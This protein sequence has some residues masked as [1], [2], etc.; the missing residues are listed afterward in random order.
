M[1]K[2]TYG[3]VSLI[4]NSADGAPT[5]KIEA[6]PQILL[7]LKNIFPRMMKSAHGY[8]TIQSTDEVCRNIEWFLMRYDLKI[9]PKALAAL[10][11]GSK[12][13]KDTIQRLEDLIDP[14][15]VA[16][17][18]PLAIPARDY[19]RQGAEIL[20]ARGG[21]LLADDVG[22]GKTV[23]AIA[24]LAAEPQTLP[25]VIVTLAG[26]M[27]SQWADHFKRFMPGASVH[28]VK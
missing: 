28:V 12:G 8:V 2:R 9:G 11:A 18:I 22:L 21:L 24:A 19:Q 4:L 27:P 17:A 26:T 13:H 16:K 7:V 3:T 20:L 23:T 6:E 1:A 14:G 10:K 15:Y 25:A 5:W